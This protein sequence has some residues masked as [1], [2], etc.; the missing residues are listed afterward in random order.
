[1]GF[2]LQILSS[3][4]TSLPVRQAVTALSLTVTLSVVEVFADFLKKLTFNGTAVTLSVVEVFST[5]YV[6]DSN[7]TPSKNRFHFNPNGK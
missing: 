1:M 3:S 4:R 2:Q 5:I 7:S 6:F